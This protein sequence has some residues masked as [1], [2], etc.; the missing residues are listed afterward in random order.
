LRRR[1]RNPK[2]AEIYLPPI[3]SIELPLHMVASER[4]I[5]KCGLLLRLIVYVVHDAMTLDSPWHLLQ[6]RQA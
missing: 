6:Q 4:C 3:L 2:G 5:T 1:A